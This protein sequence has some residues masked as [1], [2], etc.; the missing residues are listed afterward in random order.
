[1]ADALFSAAELAEAS[2]GRWVGVPPAG[3][4]GIYSDTRLDGHGKLFLALS[5]ERFD[6][7]DFLDRAESSG[8]AALCVAERKLPTVSSRLPLLVVDS[9]LLAYQRIAAFHRNRF[10]G[11]KVAAVTGSVGKTS[12]KEMIRAIFEAEAGPER[13]VATIGNTNNQV[14]VPQN[15]LRL[16]TETRFAVIEMG[17]SS[18]G[19][20]EPLSSMAK[21]DAALVNTVAP[22]H[23]EKLID[24]NG[25]AREKG[26]IFSH[27]QPDGTAVIPADLPQRAILEKAAAGHRCLYFGSGADGDFRADYLSGSL[28]GSRFLLTFPGGRS[29]EIAWNLSGAHQAANAAAAAGIASSLGIAPEVIASG[30]AKT[31]L[32]GMRMK[33]T[34]VDGVTYVNDAYNANPR[35]M[36]ASLAQFVKAPVAG[37]LWFVFGGMRELGAA[38][39][40]EHQAFFARVRREFPDAGLVLIGPEFSCVNWPQKFAASTEAGSWLAQQV[41]P[42]DMVFAK[43]SRGNAV[44][45]ALPEAAR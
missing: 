27:L 42:G 44:E 7:H 23:L 5:G 35:S 31:S 25:V 39:D 41:R 40:A 45:L 21:P 13:V 11:L 26:S 17:T 4:L 15:L 9:P 38:S 18:P 14:G 24:L 37:R 19:E 10:S 16:T 34:L 36:E 8:A 22:C 29:F 30:L 12:V 28:E 1:M 3:A 32:P 43:G 20:I 33:R 6:G 2:C